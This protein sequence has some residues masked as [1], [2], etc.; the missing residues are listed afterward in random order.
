MDNNLSERLYN[1]SDSI[2]G[3]MTADEID[4]CARHAS[5]IET[6][7]NELFAH[8]YMVDESTE[9]NGLTGEAY[10]D[11]M[12]WISIYKNRLGQVMEVNDA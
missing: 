9:G 7:V 10:V 4:S 3:G 5:E 6:R 2:G 1:L 12:K 8:I 11:F